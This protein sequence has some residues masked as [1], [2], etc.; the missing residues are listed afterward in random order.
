MRCGKAGFAD[1]WVAIPLEQG[2]FF[3]FSFSK[4]GE[5]PWVAI[6]LEQGRF[7][8]WLTSVKI[9]RKESQSLW[10]RDGFSIDGTDRRTPTNRR[11]PFGAGTVFQSKHKRQQ[12][13]HRSRNPFGAGTVFQSTQ[14]EI[15]ERA[16][17]SQSLWSRDGFSIFVNKH[18]RLNYE[19]AIPL[20]Q[21]RFFNSE[22]CFSF[23]FLG[24]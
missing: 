22:V 4:T 7:F 15:V 3:N 17:M 13:R 24:Y 19:V 2:R 23:L 16:E 18:K 12:N 21:G 14:A 8:N 9:V 6:P 20:E 1:S 5:N 10:S 11:N